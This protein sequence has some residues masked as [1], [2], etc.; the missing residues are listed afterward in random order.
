MSEQGH[1]G[2]DC[3]HYGERAE[4]LYI[5]GV[6]M[7]VEGASLS[8]EGEN[9][10]EIDPPNG[11]IHVGKLGM[12]VNGRFWWQARVMPIESSKRDTR[13]PHPSIH[14]FRFV[15]MH[16]SRYHQSLDPHY[17]VSL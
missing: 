17:I 13:P 8:K 1:D 4:S 5:S 6:D 16:L 12:D 2:S 11:T 14:L 10:M 15:G 3:T 9:L 7:H